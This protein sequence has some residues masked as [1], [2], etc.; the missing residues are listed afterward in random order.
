MAIYA[1]GSAGD[2][3]KA[4]NLYMKMRDK[5][6]E[7]DL[8]THINL[9]ICYGKAGMVE[10]VKRVYSQIEYEEIEPSES[11]FKAIIDAYKICNRKDLS[12]LVSQEMKSLFNSEEYSK[13]ESET[14]DVIGSEAEYESGSEAD[15]DYD[16][17]EAYS[18]L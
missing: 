8:V 7:P 2:I 13:I 10:G 11:L 9:V 14:E 12:E 15:Y 1:Y 18:G 16:S 3:G 4:L 5:H 6:V 17:D